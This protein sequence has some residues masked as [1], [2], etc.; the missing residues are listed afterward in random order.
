M[1]NKGLNVFNTAYILATPDT[2]TDG[3]F[4]RVKGVIAHE[5][6]HN[7]TGERAVSNRVYVGQSRAICLSQQ[8][9]VLVT[10]RARQILSDVEREPRVA[11]ATLT[12]SLD[13]LRL[14]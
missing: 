12:Q 8:R 2:A 7:W 6:F 1:E 9:E 13:V 5:Y 4:E 3:D 10:K 14:N 11:N